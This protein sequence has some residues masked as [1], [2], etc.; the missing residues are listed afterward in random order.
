MCASLFGYI[1]SRRVKLALDLRE[2]F[3]K[4]VAHGPSQSSRRGLS[5][6]GVE[7]CVT[8]VYRHARIYAAMPGLVC[9]SLQ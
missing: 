6:V 3:E 2:S 9:L 1:V 8:P 7:D 5:S 4:V